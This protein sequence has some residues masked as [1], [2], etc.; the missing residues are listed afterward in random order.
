MRPPGTE[1]R[2]VAQREPA[3]CPLKSPFEVASKV[4]EIGFPYSIS[5]IMLHPPVLP[6]EGI[7]EFHA[8]SHPT[9]VSGSEVLFRSKVILEEPFPVIGVTSLM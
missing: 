8:S 2:E 5:A 6:L 9:M 1:E 4:P 3:G 7:S